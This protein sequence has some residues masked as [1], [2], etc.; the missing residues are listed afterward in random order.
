[1]SISLRSETNSCTIVL[2]GTDR[3]SL[4]SNGNVIVNGTLI[5]PNNTIT[6]GMLT[7]TGVTAGTYGA[8]DKITSIQVGSDGRITSASNVS[9]T[10]SAYTGARSQ[11]FTANGTFTVPTGITS[12]KVRGCG[13]GGGAGSSSGIGVSG[14][15]TSFGSY[16]SA[17]GGSHGTT[18]AAGTGGASSNGDIDLSGGSGGY[19]STS[20]GG[21]C[22]SATTA[23][24][25]FSGILGGTPG[26]GSSV[27]ATGYG[28]GGA[29]GTSTTRRSGGGAGYFEKY[30]T[31]LTPGTNI[32][33]TVGVGGRAHATGNGSNGIC[34]VEW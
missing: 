9:I 5:V 15:T 6:S 8:N 17:T 12:I 21:A 18:S 24:F 25:F 31:D 11:I 34:I 13:G 19:Y 26:S 29:G 4:H 7:T 16:C 32:T 3:M 20:L 30:I 1:M 2:N 28:N 33:V 22:G 14:G 27:N 23:S 10:P